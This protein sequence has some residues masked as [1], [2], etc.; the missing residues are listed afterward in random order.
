MES[1]FKLSTTF[2]GV[3]LQK[4]GEFKRIIQNCKFEGILSVTRLQRQDR[5]AT[6]I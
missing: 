5:R 4:K 2:R 6:V 3:C 1:S